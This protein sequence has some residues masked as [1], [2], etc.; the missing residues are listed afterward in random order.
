M[1]ATLVI[2]DLTREIAVLRPWSSLEAAARLML[3]NGY[4][5]VALVND[6]RLEGVLTE[7]DLLAAVLDTRPPSIIPVSDLAA[8]EFPVGRLCEPLE[9]VLALLVRHRMERLAI[10]ADGDVFLGMISDRQICA[11][12]GRAASAQQPFLSLVR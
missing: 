4:A 3:D 6:G 2:G 11:L 1:P 7:H 12:L 5:E 9:D 8:M 10:V